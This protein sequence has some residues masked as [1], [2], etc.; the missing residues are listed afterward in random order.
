MTDKA[1]AAILGTLQSFRVTFLSVAGITFVLLAAAIFIFV[2]PRA[3][4]RSAIEIGTFSFNGREE[5]IESP[6]LLAKRIPA[7]YV[8]AA[9]AALAKNGVQQST[10]GAL[11][12]STA[13]SI[14]QTVSIQSTIDPAIAEE[15]R[16]F[17]QKIMD[18]IVEED[19]KR[20]D[21]VR[22]AA[23]SRA[24]LLKQT[25][26]GV[27]QQIADY[28]KMLD[29]V[30]ELLAETEGAIR[31]RQIERSTALQRAAT[32]LEA[33]NKAMPDIDGFRKEITNHVQLLAVL[34]EGRT[35]STRDLTTLRSRHDAL[36]SNLLEAQIA[37]R[38]FKN[39]RIALPPEVM[40]QPVGAKRLSLLVIAAVASILIAF[41][42]ISFLHSFVVTRT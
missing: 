41:G 8:P 22:D 13:D 14:G 6:E 1:A 40:L 35:Q 42:A 39:T 28:G 21:F 2:Q 11:Q 33:D 5:P 19:G 16:A 29:R 3:L 15:A 17:H 26:D 20:S 9:L 30:G 4:V 32:Q 18:Q 23:A 25:S 24:V 36:A 12:N 10:L 27:D 7:I 34:N 37:V 38:A 31:D